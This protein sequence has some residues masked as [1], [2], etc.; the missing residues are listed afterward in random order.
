MRSLVDVRLGNRGVGTRVQVSEY[1]GRDAEGAGRTG[2][3]GWWGPLALCY[4]PRNLDQI[5]GLPRLIAVDMVLYLSV[6]SDGC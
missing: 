4:G 5:I 1:G 3:M 2:R 6:M